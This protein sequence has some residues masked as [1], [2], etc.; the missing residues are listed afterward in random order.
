MPIFPLFVIELITVLFVEPE[1]IEMPYEAFPDVEIEPAL[2]TVFPAD[3][4]LLA[5]IVMPSALGPVVIIW[6]KIVLVAV[7]PPY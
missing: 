3:P 1:T 5:E 7:L 4:A 6:P 2:V